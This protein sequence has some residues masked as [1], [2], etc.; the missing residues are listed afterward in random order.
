MVY[1]LY[2]RQCYILVQGLLNEILQAYGN[3]SFVW[4]VSVYLI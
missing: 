2:L 1:K 3:L 4:V